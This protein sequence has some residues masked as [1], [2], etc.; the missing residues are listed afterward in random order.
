[1]SHIPVLNL[2]GDHEIDYGYANTDLSTSTL[3]FSF[4]GNY[5]F[6]AYAARYPVPGTPLRSVGSIDKS[7]YYST[8]VGGVIKL[9]VLNNYLPFHP[10]TPQHVWASKELSSVDR[11]A[12]PWL[13]VLTHAPA[14]HTYVKHYKESECF[15]W[16]TVR[17]NIFIGIY[18]K[19][20]NAITY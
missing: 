19:M 15:M 9:I 10:G 11:T 7:L 17:R 2:I 20:F 16:V 12:T 13:F 3:N 6:Q 4:P 8:V 5:P 14:Y 18:R 1:M